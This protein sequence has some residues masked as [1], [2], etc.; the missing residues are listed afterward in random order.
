MEFSHIFGSVS[1]V[2]TT[3]GAGYGLYHPFSAPTLTADN[4]NQLQQLVMTTSNS[5]VSTGAIRKISHH[6]LRSLVA[7]GGDRSNR[8]IIVSGGFNNTGRQF[9][10]FKVRIDL[11]FMEMEYLK[12]LYEI[13]RKQSMGI[14]LKMQ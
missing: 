12:Y 11:T 14:V 13:Y 7:V 4:I 9:N 6:S 8:S 3:G 1:S 10:R 5:A 2:E